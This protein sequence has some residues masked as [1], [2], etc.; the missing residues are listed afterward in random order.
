MLS[1]ATP[2]AS[3]PPPTS[4]RGVAIAVAA[5]QVELV[6]DGLVVEEILH[7]H[8]VRYR[9]LVRRIDG[10]GLVDAQDLA[11]KRRKPVEQTV[12]GVSA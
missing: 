6:G 12:R 3:P 8:V 4:F 1:S 2:P 11:E 10:D 9:S 5:L 7:H